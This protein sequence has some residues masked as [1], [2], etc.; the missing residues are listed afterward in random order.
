VDVIGA[1]DDQGSRP[2]DVGS[3]VIEHLGVSPRIEIYIDVDERQFRPFEVRERAVEIMAGLEVETGPEGRGGY[4]GRTPIPT[5]VRGCDQISLAGA[6]F[7]NLGQDLWWEPV[8]GN[9]R[10]SDGPNR[11]QNLREITFDA[12]DL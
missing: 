12:I 1:L 10:I 6:K 11:L 2:C 8:D 4:E 7:E 9:R 5:D 3:D